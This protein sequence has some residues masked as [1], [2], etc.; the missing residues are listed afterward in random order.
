MPMKLYV[1][2]DLQD[3]W[4]CLHSWCDLPTHRIWTGI[5][6]R[7]IPDIFFDPVANVL[8]QTLK[9]KI[10]WTYV[11]QKYIRKIDEIT[12][13]NVLS[14][15]LLI[16]PSTSSFRSIKCRLASTAKNAPVRPLPS[17]QWTIGGPWMIQNIWMI[18]S[19]KQF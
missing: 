11:G 16:L 4:L 13:K 7:L 15:K 8:F 2:K 10:T 17:W 1:V 18:T 5:G 3:Q 19:R 12:L 14:N 9:E 6:K